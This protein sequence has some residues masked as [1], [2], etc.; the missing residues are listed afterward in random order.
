MT[1]QVYMQW[2]IHRNMHTCIPREAHRPIIAYTHAYIY[3]CA[4]VCKA[5]QCPH[6]Q[7]QSY[8]LYMCTTHTH[9][10]NGMCIHP[11]RM[12][13]Y[14]DLGKWGWH[15]FFMLPHR[16]QFISSGLGRAHCRALWLSTAGAIPRGCHT[17]APSLR[18][19][20]LEPQVWR[21]WV[22]G[23][24]ASLRSFPTSV[25]LG[26]PSRSLPPHRGWFKSGGVPHPCPQ[27]AILP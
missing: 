25:F 9:A 26:T 1:W 10:H 17:G 8:V 23:P 5:T 13:L 16:Q 14:T 4:Y 15:V 27:N 2:H 12:D 18:R 21:D 6:T 3:A 19:D 7:R 22:S 24:E 11:A 20:W